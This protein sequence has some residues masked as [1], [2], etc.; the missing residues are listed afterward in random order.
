MSQDREFIKKCLELGVVAGLCGAAKGAADL[1]V[2]L[3]EVG[4]YTTRCHQSPC[5]ELG[6]G[7]PGEIILS[8]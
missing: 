5:A 6:L 8:R 3:E 1:L 4:G 2:A 7:P